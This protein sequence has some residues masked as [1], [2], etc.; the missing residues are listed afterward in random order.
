MKKRKQL[1]NKNL[2]IFQYENKK[3]KQGASGK[4]WKILNLFLWLKMER[5]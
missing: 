2:Y 4:L 1:I 5:K 3:I